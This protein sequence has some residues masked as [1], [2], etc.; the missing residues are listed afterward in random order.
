MCTQTYLKMTFLLA[1]VILWVVLALQYCKYWPSPSQTQK[2]HNTWLRSTLY[3]CMRTLYVVRCTLYVVRCT[4]YNCTNFLRLKK[5]RIHAVDV[6]S[7]LLS[8]AH[9]FSICANNFKSKMLRVWTGGDSN[10]LVVKT[11]DKTD[12]IAR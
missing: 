7:D 3:N 4:L 1:K 11:T 6:D 5:L 10:W 9:Q 12:L 2:I 8:A